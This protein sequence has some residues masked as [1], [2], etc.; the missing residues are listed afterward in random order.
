VIYRFSI[1]ILL[2]GH[3][4]FYRVLAELGYVGSESWSGCEVWI[5]DRFVGKRF[6]FFLRVI[7]GSWGWDEG[8]GRLG[9]VCWADLTEAARE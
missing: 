2:F 5:W 8:F 9:E 3:R 4:S 1:L 6:I 7:W